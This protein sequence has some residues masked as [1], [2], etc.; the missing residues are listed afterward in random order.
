MQAYQVFIR[1]ILFVVLHVPL[2]VLVGLLVA[3]A[4]IF[5]R[6]PILS[7]I[8]SLPYIIARGM[9]KW[10]GIL[11]NTGKWSVVYDSKTKLPLDPAY[12]TVRNIQ[13]VE[14]ASVIT[15]IDGRFAL[16]LPPGIY[17]IDVQKT[18]Y[19][20]PS[21]EMK[22]TKTD[23]QYINLYYGERIELA[24]EGSI[25]ISIPMDQLGS[26]WNQ[27]EKARKNVFL[28]F[29][30]ED[31]LAASEALYL[32]IGL[33]VVSVQ[34][35]YYKD[36]FL[37][38]LFLGYCVV[39]FA[40]A[41]W[42]VFQSEKMGHSYVVDRKGSSVPFARVTVFR[43]KSKNQL[44]R[45]TTSFEGQFTALVPKGKYY[46]TIETRDAA[47]GYTLVHTSSTFHVSRGWIGKKFTI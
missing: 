29:G 36:A 27:E 25:H 33:I 45:T 32:V 1:S 12:V 22:K 28:R 2:S 26:D 4:L 44:L 34:Y 9:G 13:G 38:Q 40:K 19:A 10:L 11:K 35:L 37:Y 5:I 17:T 31:S 23:G 16:I 14:I 21:Y 18:N 20:F 30:N 46:L 24:R 8:L 7:T 47:G 42:F 6:I 43:A 41:V 15:D 39:I 3:A